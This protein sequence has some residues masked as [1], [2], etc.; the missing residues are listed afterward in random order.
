MLNAKGQRC[1]NEL[2]RRDHVSNA[3][4]QGKAGPYRLV[5]NKKASDEILWHCKHYVGRGLMKQFPTGEA[6]AKEMGISVKALQETFQQYNADAAAGGKADAYGKKVFRNTPFDVK[7]SF[8]AAIITPVVH[9]TMGGL[10]VNERT[11]V[12]D[13]EEGIP[14]LPT[15]RERRQVVYG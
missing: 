9:Y 5:L 1:V 2:G 7:D 10:R 13:E 14:G 11:H 4:L 12:L 15:M 8:F 3:M 6:L